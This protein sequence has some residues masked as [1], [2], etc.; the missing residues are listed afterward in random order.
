MQTLLFV[1]I[2][3][4]EIA[5]NIETVPERG[6]VPVAQA[7]ADGQPLGFSMPGRM[8][9]DQRIKLIPLGLHQRTPGSNEL[10]EEVSFF[11]YEL[12]NVRWER[13]TIYVQ[14]PWFSLKFRF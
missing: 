10:S 7:R 5:W 9:A 11:L 6:S 3:E 13:W 8:Q 1:Y 14:C 12:E 4:Y 2:V